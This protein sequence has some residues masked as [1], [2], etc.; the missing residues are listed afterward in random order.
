ME[1]TVVNRFKDRGEAGMPRSK[2]PVFVV[3]CPRSG[4]TF[5]FDALCSS[6]VFP[7]YDQESHVFGG[8]VT[9]VGDLSHRKNREE[10]F[11]RWMQSSYFKPTGVDLE[12]VKRRILEECN[13][14][15]DF[16]RIVMEE[17]ARQ[18][19]KDR[20]AEHTP[21]HA[22]YLK[23][24]KRTLP[25]ALFL[26]LIRD[27][28]DVAL[29]LDRQG[30]LNSYLLSPKHSLVACG[31]YW[32][33]LVGAG[34]RAGAAIGADYMEVRFEDLITKPHETFAKIGQFIDE[35]LDY[36]RIRQQG[37]GA[38]NK[39]NTSFKA[40]STKTGFDPVSRWKRDYPK[41][42]LLKL[43]G[44]I[45][46]FLKKIGYQLA[47]PESDLGSPFTPRSLR[48][49]YRNYLASRLFAKTYFPMARY[50][51]RDR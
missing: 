32:E 5:L 24:I 20:W 3:G 42:E 10:L 36:D 1:L 29:S 16:L 39:P 25:D 17:M 22:L 21:D 23:E 2:A 15:G 34:M 14:G 45:G 41:G 8:L 30:F 46:P 51:V 40:E 37:V 28:R 31:V 13:N 18:Q 49:L 48:A 12:E 38:V 43:E 7:I 6:G 50:F 11:A 44:A 26:H 35:D 19:N 4:T 47:T 33:W 9:R 27:G